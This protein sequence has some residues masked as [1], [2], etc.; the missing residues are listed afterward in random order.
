MHKKRFHN[1]TDAIFAIII[2]IIILSLKEPATT[3]KTALFSIIEPI[4]AYAISFFVLWSNWYSIHELLKNIESV[5]YKL[6]YIMGA[7]LFSQSFIPFSTGWIGHNIFDLTSSI[8]YLFIC[9]FNFF[10]YHFFLEPEG[11]HLTP[12][13]LRNALNKN[14]ITK[15]IRIFSFSISFLFIYWFPPISLILMFV[16]SLLHFIE[17]RK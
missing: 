11:I 6:Y 10:I 1:F 4:I 8:F 3:G 5:S 14:P 16:L 15:I 2:T 13:N 7:T 12:P 17:Q 9:F